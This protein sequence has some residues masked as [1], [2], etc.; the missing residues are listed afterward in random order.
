MTYATW[1]LTK[2]NMDTPYMTIMGI[3]VLRSFGMALT[4]I[5]VPIE[6]AS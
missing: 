3:Y 4:K 1:E 2:L 6:P 5:A